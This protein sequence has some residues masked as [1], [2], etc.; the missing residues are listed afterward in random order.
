ML[1]DGNH[2]S[3]SDWSCELDSVYT[4]LIFALYTE[5]IQYDMYDD[6]KNKRIV[7]KVCA[8]AKVDV[9]IHVN[10]SRAEG[11]SFIITSMLCSWL[12]DALIKEI[13]KAYQDERPLGTWRMQVGKGQL[14]CHGVKAEKPDDCMELRLMWADYNKIIKNV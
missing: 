12:V 1:G 10:S 6:R 7:K 13:N 2:C 8:G 14:P 9:N 4:N 5:L 3:Y 11:Y